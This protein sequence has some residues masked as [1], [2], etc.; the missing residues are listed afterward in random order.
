MRRAA[1]SLLS[2][3]RIPVSTTNPKQAAHYNEVVRSS[4]LGCRF[5]SSSRKPRQLNR[6]RRTRMFL[7]RPQRYAKP[8]PLSRLSCSLRIIGNSYRG[9]TRR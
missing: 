8:K 3:A 9:M 7:A 1:A 4:F 5:A 2:L 6:R